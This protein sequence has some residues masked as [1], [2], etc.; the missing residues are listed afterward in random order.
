MGAPGK[1]SYRGS[2]GGRK[3]HLGDC[4]CVIMPHKCMKCSRTLLFLRVDPHGECLSCR[5][6]LL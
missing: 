5:E 6:V 3:G 1:R 4:K 2:G